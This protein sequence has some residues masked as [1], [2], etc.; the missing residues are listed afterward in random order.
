[1]EWSWRNLL[2]NEIK[3]ICFSLL[4]FRSFI[5]GAIAV[6]SFAFNYFCGKLEQSLLTVVHPILF[7]SALWLCRPCNGNIFLHV[8]GSA[9][10]FCWFWIWGRW[11]D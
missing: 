3:L 1:M 5:H 11:V 9:S 4:S 10:A 2:V 6:L 7:C 8:S